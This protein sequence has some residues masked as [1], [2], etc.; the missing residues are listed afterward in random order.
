MQEENTRQWKTFWALRGAYPPPLHHEMAS[1]K[2][3]PF[4]TKVGSIFL[5][6]ILDYF[7]LHSIK[8]E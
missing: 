2:E 5:V 3:V 4:P 1:L 6:F 8:S 7:Y